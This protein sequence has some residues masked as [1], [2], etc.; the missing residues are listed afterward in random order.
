LHWRVE[1][2]EEHQR[3]D[4]NN[5][6]NNNNNYSLSVIITPTSRRRL[7]L[8]SK[9]LHPSTVQQ[10][11]RVRFTSNLVQLPL[12]QLWTSIRR[13]TNNLRSSLRS[14]RFAFAFKTK[15]VN[16]VHPIHELRA[17]SS[18]SVSLGKITENI[19]PNLVPK[20]K[21][22]RHSISILYLLNSW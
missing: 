12:K 2:K 9:Q 8:S 18:D 5:K 15:T 4:N 6:K 19:K 14:N 1:D 7:P 21:I 13:S 10:P 16:Q 11:S 3:K 20:S 17:T 22:T